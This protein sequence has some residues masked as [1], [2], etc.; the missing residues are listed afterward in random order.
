MMEDS[1]E[2][3]A[4]CCVWGGG[5]ALLREAIRSKMMAAAYVLYK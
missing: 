4:M 1:I 5:G 3:P 2:P